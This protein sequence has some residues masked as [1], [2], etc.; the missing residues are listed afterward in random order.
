M[1][2][3]S[4]VG[5]TGALGGTFLVW[6]ACSTIYS[7]LDTNIFSRSPALGTPKRAAL[8][9]PIP[10]RLYGLLLGAVPQRLRWDAAAPP[11]LDPG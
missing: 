1:C 4:E 3:E 6:L 11:R 5:T 8:G 2:E 7:S 9:R 10:R